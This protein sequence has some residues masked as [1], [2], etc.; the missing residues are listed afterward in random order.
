M[1]WHRDR[2]RS[3]GCQKVTRRGVRLL[4]RRRWSFR[5]V[6]EPLPEFPEAAAI[7][8]KTSAAFE[9]VLRAPGAGSEVPE[10]G[11]EFASTRNFTMTNENQRNRS[12]LELTDRLRDRIQRLDPEKVVRVVRRLM[13]DAE[14]DPSDH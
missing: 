6:S 2:N 7:A 4:V 14:R 12:D 3:N 10:A 8:H 9:R 11:K 1:V 5:F 13:D